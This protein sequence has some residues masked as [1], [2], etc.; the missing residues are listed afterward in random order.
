MSITGNKATGVNVSGEANTVTLTGDM[1]VDKDQKSPQ[2]K[3]YFV[4]PSYGI[5]VS[6]SGN[7][8][9]LDGHL[10]VIVDT[11]S[12]AHA[13]LQR[14]GAVEAIRGVVVS[15]DN[16]RVDLLGG[17]S[18]LVKSIKLTAEKDVLLVAIVVAQ[19]SPLTVNHRFTC[20]V[21]HPSMVTTR[22]RLK[23]YLT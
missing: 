11:E 1:V 9:V 22:Q 13:E 20:M 18:L 6:G 23:A 4:T 12:F 15:G 19:Q 3:D 5:N 17:L 8:V 7:T 10:Q 2:A 14:D 21:T 16:N